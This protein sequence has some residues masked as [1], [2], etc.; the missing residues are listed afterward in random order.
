LTK[1]SLDGEEWLIRHDEDLIF[2]PEGEGYREWGDARPLGMH[3]CKL[4]P[5][6]QICIGHTARIVVAAVIITGG[7]TVLIIVA[8][9]QHLSCPAEEVATQPPR[10][11]WSMQVAVEV[12]TLVSK[13]ADEPA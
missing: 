2:D 9:P 3:Q 12:L 7:S 11:E 1:P 6:V 8:G 4:H 13:L 5:I 10:Y